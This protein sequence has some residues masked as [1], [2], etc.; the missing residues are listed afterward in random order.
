MSLQ[1]DINDKGHRH[2]LLATPAM[3]QL[4]GQCQ[5]W[6]MDSTFKVIKDRSV[7]CLPFMALSVLAK[8]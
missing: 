8:A 5:H 7:S 4:L 6:Y 3:L 1:G 2:V